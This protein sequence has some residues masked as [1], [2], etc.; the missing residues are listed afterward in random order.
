MRVCV[1]AGGGGADSCVATRPAK[2][3]LPP[4]QAGWPGGWVHVQ[5]CICKRCMRAPAALPLTS[6]P[7]GHPPA[8]PAPPAGAAAPPGWCA[9]SCCPGRW[10]A[11]APQSPGL[12]EREGPAGP[13]MKAGRQ[14]A[15]LAGCGWSVGAGRQARPACRRKHM[16]QAALSRM[17]LA[18]SQVGP[19]S[20]P[21]LGTANP[22]LACHAA[23]LALGQLHAHNGARRVAHRHHGAHPQGVQQ[24]CMGRAGQRPPEP[25][26][27]GGHGSA[28]LVHRSKVRAATTVRLPSLRPVIR[29]SLSCWRGGCQLH[30]RQA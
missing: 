24:A 12:Q 7:A 18:W 4:P 23:R 22:R 29:T 17:Q 15:G 14:V 20:V 1:W 9:A 2:A 21:A 3:C 10:A 11:R 6:G 30:P 8:A 13:G 26:H 19:A 16:L 27:V 5:G 28:L 25:R